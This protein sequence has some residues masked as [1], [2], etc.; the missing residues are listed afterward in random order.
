MLTPQ[1]KTKRPRVKFTSKFLF[2]LL[3][4]ITIAGIVIIT[5]H[6][7]DTSTSRKILEA[8]EIAHIR[9]EQD[10]IADDFLAIIGD[11]A[12]LAHSPLLG[13]FLASLNKQSRRRRKR[14]KIP[15]G[16]TRKNSAPFQISPTLGS[17][18]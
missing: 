10:V 14:Q 9:L 5:F 1:S 3:P 11:F 6:L 2:Y 7:P 15:S 17:T 13:D 12:V 8:R 4:A 16:Q 18:G